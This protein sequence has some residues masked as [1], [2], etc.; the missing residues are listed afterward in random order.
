MN[1]KFK[2]AALCFKIEHLK[3]INDMYLHLQK[4]IHPAKYNKIE[5]V[6]TLSIQTFLT[7]RFVLFFYLLLLL[8]IQ[9]CIYLIQITAKKT[10]LLF[11]LTVFYLKIYF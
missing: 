1:R 11:K 9:A 8:L 5:L 3:Y 7:V 10:V 6:S 4:I 2:T